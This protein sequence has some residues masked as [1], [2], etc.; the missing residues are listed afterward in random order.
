[1]PKIG[2][3]LSGGGSR[4]ISQLGFIKY[5]EEQCIE[6]SAISGA[7]G[8]AIIGGLYATGKSIDE[9][10]STLKR[11]DFKSH[12][13]YNINK[14]TLYSFQRAI[15]YFQ[16]QFGHI[17]IKDLEVPFFC[18]V[19]DYENGEIVYKTEGDLVTYMLASSALVPI[20]S[21]IKHEGKIYVDG[22]ICD[23]LPTLPLTKV[24]DKII[25]INVNPISKNIKYSFK[26]HLQRSMFM[27]LNANVENSK[28][29]SDLFVEITQMGRYSIFDLENF[30]LFFEIGYNEAKRYDREIEEL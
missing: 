29:M 13:K 27:M 18:A 24:C 14:G 30:D 2:L 15:P 28:K 17:D 23:N 11:T 9:I 7:S 25:A 16:K 1:M 26:G 12:L 4:C 22:G 8:G 5:L 19:T 10:F 6:I 3:T 21:P 20:F